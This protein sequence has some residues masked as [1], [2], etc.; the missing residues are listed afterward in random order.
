MIKSRL[1]W[2]ALALSLLVGI[3][4]AEAGTASSTFTVTATVTSACQINSTS[5]IAFGNYDPVNANK[6]TPATSTGSIAVTCTKTTPATI[7]LDQG[8]NASASSTCDAPVRQMISGT[9]DLQYSIYQDTNRSVVWG[10]GTSDEQSF[11]ST[12]GTAPT[13]FTTYGSI[14]AAQ[15]VPSGSYSD[16]VTVTVT[17]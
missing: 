17:F 7:A 9:N 14:P 10:C 11:T 3:P 5:S 6:S 16:T 15:D 1:S 2:L 8:L 12:T 13:N 4:A